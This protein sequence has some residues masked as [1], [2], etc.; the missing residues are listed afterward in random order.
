M[1]KHNFKLKILLY[2]FVVAIIPFAVSWVFTYSTYDRKA[3]QDFKNFNYMYVQNQISKIGLVFDEQENIIK[4]IAQAYSYID[5]N[6]SEIKSFLAD[7]SKINNNFL[8]L[9]IITPNGKIY[10]KDSEKPQNSMNYTLLHSYTDARKAQ[11]LVW[12]EPYTDVISG[13][14][15]IGMSIPLYDRNGGELGVLVG[16]I[17]LKKFDAMISSA[18]Y[19]SDVELFFVNSSG[20][21]KFHSEN[22]YSEIVNI[23]DSNFVL[24]PIADSIFSLNEGYREFSSMGKNW[25]SSFSVINSNGWKIVSLVDT[26]KFLSKFSIVN[27]DTN[28]LTVV[29]AVLCIFVALLASI[30]LSGSIT[31]PLTVLRDGAKEF[32]R[33]KLDK[34]IDI[35]SHD[36]IQEVADAFNEMAENL[37][38]TYSDL[39]ER[40]DELYKNNEEL[41][42]AN[43]ELE[44]SYEQLEATMGQL[45]VSEEKYRSLMDNISD[46]VI[47]V[48]LDEKI[49]YVNNSIENILGYSESELIGKPVSIIVKNSEAAF[50]HLDS[51]E[52]YWEF[53]R[54]F[55]KKDGSIIIAEGSTK[56]VIEEDRTVG[57]QSIARDVTQ[58]IEME[59]Q[60]RKK[61]NELQT[62]NKI[63]LTITSSMDLQSILVT[64]INQ[65]M[66]VSD[67]L[68]C[69]IRLFEDKDPNILVLKAIR[70]I[71]AEK[72]DRRDI[73][74]SEDMIGAAVKSKITVVNELTEDNAPSGYY[75]TL[76]R[77]EQ[78]RYVA[79]SPLT[80]KSS[81]IG[82]MTT[83]SKEKPNEEKIELLNS[84]ANNLAMVIDNARAYD[85]LKRSYLQTVQ[86]LVSVVEAKDEYTESHSIRVAKYASFIA[87]EMGYP[88]S[89]IED[90]WVA[91]VLHDI[92]KIGI[93]D[94]ILNKKGRLTDEEYEI[95]KQHPE[96][97][98]KIVSKIGLSNDILKAI[99]HH[100]E[101]YDGRG[102]PDRINGEDVSIMAAIISVSD[103][104]DAITSNRPYRESRNLKDGIKEIIV[105]KGTQ[106]NP[107][108]ADTLEKVFLIK[109]KVME[110]IFNG[111]DI[112]FF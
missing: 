74:I 49:V 64:V 69:S 38:E 108:V 2:F 72:Y 25:I 43:A 110:R 22:K 105:N 65:V 104:F 63:S 58:K 45:N 29:L 102:Y 32:S 51:D 42:E 73:N 44:A 21:V 13:E 54:E 28:V 97:A 57:I 82:V 3:Q 95:I 18:K 77:E 86:S 24:S 78:A 52:H 12:L 90:I 81:L 53:Q 26:D 16:N 9:Y 59:K 19:M 87:S 66:N 103:A 1:H 55:V 50:R 89:F 30:F 96:I 107:R 10:L 91:G 5:K 70:G 11:H 36:E 39:L 23:K 99:R 109:P 85:T 14:K 111:E 6:E 17:S 15:C 75:R 76:Y 48:N 98:Y 94:S 92:G 46:M 56:R 61:Y 101:R 67:A 35:R 31:K 112:K 27:Q 80:V 79:F 41:Q 8:N 40:T 47:A 84:L 7:Q 20:Y 60:L 83:V 62:L 100:H 33:G 37:K 68:V 93:S 88:K 4:S 71:N 106:F 34:R